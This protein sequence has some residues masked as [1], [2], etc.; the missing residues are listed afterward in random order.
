MRALSQTIALEG[1][2]KGCAFWLRSSLLLE[3]LGCTT[4]GLRFLVSDDQ[5]LYEPFKV[6]GV[7]HASS[8]NQDPPGPSL[9]IDGFDVKRRAYYSP[10]REGH[11]LSVLSREVQNGTE[12]LG[13]FG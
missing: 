10:L 12:L 4:C 11:R 9:G 5:L 8:Q 1:I 13:L 2:P 7:D 6:V 3:H